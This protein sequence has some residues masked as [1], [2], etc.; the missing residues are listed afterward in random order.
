VVVI[1]PHEKSGLWSAFVNLLT[2]AIGVGI[3]S[4]P[5]AFKSAG[6]VGITVLGL[7]FAALNAYTLWLLARF[8]HRHAAH[9]VTHPTYEA[10]VRRVLG[11]RFGFP[12]FSSPNAPLT[13]V[14]CVSCVSCVAC[15]V[16]VV[17]VVCGCRAYAVV[18]AC[19]LF[20]TVGA[21]SA[22]LIV[23]GDLVRHATARATHTHTRHTTQI[24]IRL[25]TG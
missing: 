24:M 11:P 4:F 15:V 9:L 8:A 18:E 2:G 10:L 17:R 21:L 6:L 20:N 12:A 13:R 3:L 16:C 5:Y 22:F 23:V 1:L 7:L 14:S 25:P 19:I